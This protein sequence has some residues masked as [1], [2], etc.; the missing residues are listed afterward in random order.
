MKALLPKGF[1]KKAATRIASWPGFFLSPEISYVPFT[2]AQSRM[3][4]MSSFVSNLIET[5]FLIRAFLAVSRIV[6]PAAVAVSAE[7][8]P[9][10]TIVF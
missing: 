6:L 4:K 7:K 9:L 10:Q 3:K 8:V 5:I 1:E 2:A